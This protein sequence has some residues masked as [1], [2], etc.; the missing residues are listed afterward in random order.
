MFVLKLY[1][2]NLLDN[3]KSGLVQVYFVFVF[4]SSNK[5]VSCLL[6]KILHF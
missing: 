4:L 2:S 5:S 3:I 6:L 1:L